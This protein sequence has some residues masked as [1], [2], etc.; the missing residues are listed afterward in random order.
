M[1]VQA[2]INAYASPQFQ[3]WKKAHPKGNE[4]EILDLIQS[5]SFKSWVKSN[6]NGTVDQYLHH[7]QQLRQYRES[8]QYRIEVLE[9]Q[10]E[11]LRTGIQEMHKDNRALRMEI[12]EK[13]DEISNLSS[14]RG[15]LAITTI[16]FLL[17]S[18]FLYIRLKRTKMA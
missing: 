3:Q 9:G 17:V 1:D 2:F 18:V 4:S 11:E 6:P 16:L 13:D 14:W 7:C 10:I 8:P 15:S 12:S 5:L